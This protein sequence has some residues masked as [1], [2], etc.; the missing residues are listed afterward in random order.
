MRLYLE[1]YRG[2]HAILLATAGHGQPWPVGWIPGMDPGAKRLFKGPRGPKAPLGSGG[3]IMQYMQ[4]FWLDLYRSANEG[5]Q[6][7]LHDHAEDCPNGSDAMHN[8]HLLA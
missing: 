8:V 6:S 4:A 5:I 3:L 1:L 7:T 2:R